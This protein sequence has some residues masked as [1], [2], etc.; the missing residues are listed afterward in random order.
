MLWVYQL[1]SVYIV[2]VSCCLLPQTVLCEATTTHPEV[3]SL[4]AGPQKQGAAK[5]DYRGDLH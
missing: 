4:P 3:T 5:E 2:G 1:V